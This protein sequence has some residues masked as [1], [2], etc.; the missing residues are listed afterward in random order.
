MTSTFLSSFELIPYGMIAFGKVLAHYLIVQLLL[1][2]PQKL[3]LLKKHF[4]WWHQNTS[5]RHA[6]PG[7]ATAKQKINYSASKTT[8]C[9]ANFRTVDEMAD[10][11]EN[12]KKTSGEDFGVNRVGFSFQSV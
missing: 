8:V 4:P 6:L 1:A 10:F 11:I 3:A 9:P 5:H 7:Q 2:V 12:A